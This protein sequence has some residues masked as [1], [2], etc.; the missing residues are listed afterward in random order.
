MKTKKLVLIL[1]AL[2][3][4]ACSPAASAAP[5]E[6]LPPTNTLA[7]AA[8]LEQPTPAPFLLSYAFP[9]RIDPAKR[10][11]FYLHGK[12]IEDQGIPAVSPDYGAYEYQAILEKLNSYGFV[13]IS[14]QRA[15][16]TDPAVY[17]RRV[18][19]QVTTLLNAGVP[20][21]NITVVGASKGALITVYA[22]H[23][24]ANKDL[25]F[26]IL[27]VCNPEAFDAFKRDQAFLYGNILS[28]YDSADVYA[29]SCQD[30][31]AFSEGK[32]I[33]RHEEM[34]LHLG[35]GHGILY[36]PLDE[37]I[38][39]VIR[40]ASASATNSNYFYRSVLQL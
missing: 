29:G 31:Y 13:V 19:E 1:L 26:A 7:P 37:W 38:I 32:G 30:L 10:Y 4:A 20:A 17:A 34:V 27:A 35:A 3:L 23:F 14:E 22:A 12:I 40:F 8:T 28:L 25:S 9:E 21:A 24:L 2:G 39:P 16:N 15:K 5:T 33:A 6:T 18:A 11:L 36:Q